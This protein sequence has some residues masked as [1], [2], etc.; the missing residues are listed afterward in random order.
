MKQ[1]QFFFL[2]LFVFT[3]T[4]QGGAQT[5]QGAQVNS[6]EYQLIRE[7]TDSIIVLVRQDYNLYSGT[8][9]YAL[10]DRNYFGRKYSLGVYADGHIWIDDDDL[11]P[12]MNDP[13][14]EPY[15]NNDTLIPVL[16]NTYIRPL[17]DSSFHQVTITAIDTFPRELAALELENFPCMMGSASLIDSIQPGWAIVVFP[18]ASLDSV[19]SCPL[20]V[21]VYYSYAEQYPSIGDYRVPYGTAILDAIGGAFFTSEVSTGEMHLRFAG[22][23]KPKLLHFQVLPMPSALVELEGSGGGPPGSTEQP[24]S[25]TLQSSEPNS[26]RSLNPDLENENHPSGKKKR[27]K[28]EKNE[29]KNPGG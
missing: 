29:R 13:V 16:K 19:P 23:L 17:Y 21:K 6:L 7:M 1:F 8:Q 10:G 18:L 3:L 20:T 26:L 28:R 12:W 14:Y 24:P 22:L 11:T 4:I 2:V 5:V 9:E 25:P 27:K 15:S